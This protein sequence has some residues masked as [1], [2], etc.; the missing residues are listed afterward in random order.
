MKKAL[1]IFI[2][3]VVLVSCLSFAV[4]AK[5]TRISSISI[6]NGKNFQP[7]KNNLTIIVKLT[8]ITSK[9]K[10][11]IINSEKKVV[12]TYSAKNVKTK[13]IVWNGKNSKGSY[14]SAG[15]YK[16]KA[17]VGK[18]SKFSKSITLKASSAFLGGKGTK[19]SPY[20]VGSI[21]QLKKLKL[22]N[23]CYF[24]QNNDID[25]NYSYIKLFSESNPFIGN[26]NGNGH[27]INNLL[28]S[29][30]DYYKDFGMF[31]AIG[32]KGV[33]KNI[34]FNNTTVSCGNSAGVVAAIN[35]GTIENCKVY[36]TVDTVNTSRDFTHETGMVCGLNR[37]KII[38]CSAKGTVSAKYDSEKD[39]RYI[40]SHGGGIVGNN[41]GL[42]TLC[43]TNVVVEVTSGDT[44]CY[45]GGIVAY[46][47]GVVS[48]CTADGSVYAH[49]RTSL[50]GTGDGY[51]GGIV[52]YNAATVKGCVFAGNA[53]NITGDNTGEIFGGKN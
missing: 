24:I 1:S 26:Y 10:I 2:C 13:K 39:A 27:T 46:N 49:A 52:G 22:Y 9:M 43:T 19:T 44:D 14:V 32:S 5:T 50:F 37:G 42:V 12:R 17:V 15:K 23:G 35:D 11:S 33:V 34:K 48:D 45:A 36:G 47:S 21:S 20:K 40:K 6:K 38:N 16:V 4:N 41:T 25:F 18:V 31:S 30:G 53:D 51:S 28:F 3:F 8:S 29:N 7:G